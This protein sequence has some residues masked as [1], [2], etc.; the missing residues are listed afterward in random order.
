MKKTWYSETRFFV[1]M[2]RP[3]TGYQWSNLGVMGHTPLGDGPMSAAVM[4]YRIPVSYERR[5]V[6]WESNLLH[7]FLPL[8]CTAG[9]AHQRLVSFCRCV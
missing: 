7:C 2:Q 3:C 1:V 4:D 5:P 8:L 9:S 6:L